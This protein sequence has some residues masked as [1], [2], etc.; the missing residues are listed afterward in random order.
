MFSVI[1][2]AA[3]IILPF[4]PFAQKFFHFASPPALAL[5]TVFLLVISYAVLSEITK[6]MYFKY[7]KPPKKQ[8]LDFNSAENVVE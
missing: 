5:L 1:V 6:Q 2:A 7:F 3:T 8:L 4:F